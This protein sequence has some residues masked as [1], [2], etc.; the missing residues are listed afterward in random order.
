[1]PINSKRILVVE[2]DP[3]LQKM[4]G[5]NLKADGY[6]VVCVG[7]GVDA[8]EVIRN[9]RI[10]AIVLDVM[11][12]VLDGFQVCTTMR[13]EG[14]KMPILFLTAKN[15]GP[16]RVEGLK[17][18][19]DDYL[20]KP[21]NVEELLLRLARLIEQSRRSI[22][23]DSVGSVGVALDI[24]VY[25]IGAGEVRFDKFQIKN[26]EGAI[27]QISKRESMLLK[28]LTSRVGDVV[29]RK[30]ILESVWGYSVYPS[31]RTIDNYLL[32]FRK[33]FEP[34][35]KKPVYFHSVRGVGYRFEE[36]C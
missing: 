22:E 15:S 34:N 16:E 25:K 31:T 7:D 18:G 4:L 30:E 12:P 32:G 33:Y 11:L 13:L 29:S 2:D 3:S 23:K 21:F 35:P 8:L 14:H 6:H 26:H 36:I 17:L 20:G 27:Q 10:D 9:Q 28:L 19:A 24:E 1:M 5:M